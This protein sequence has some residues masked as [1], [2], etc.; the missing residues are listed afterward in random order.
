M[1]IQI[2]IL[3]VLI[4]VISIFCFN[5]CNCTMLMFLY[6]SC[7]HYISFTISRGNVLL[8]VQ[9]SNSTAY[10]LNIVFFVHPVIF[11]VL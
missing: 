2:F 11:E 3:E 6:R 10:S 1:Y 7:N 5:I 4:M 8:Y 9:S